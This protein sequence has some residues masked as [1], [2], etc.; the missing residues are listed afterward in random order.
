[1][2]KESTTIDPVKNPGLI[3]IPDELYEIY[4]PK[5]STNPNTILNIFVYLL[6]FCFPASPPSF[7]I[8]SNEGIIQPN[9]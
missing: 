4:I 6:I 5:P 9:N 7:I 3:N 2:I 8:F 1:M